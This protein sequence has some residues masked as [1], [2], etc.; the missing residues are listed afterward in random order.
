VDDLSF[1]AEFHRALDPMA[2]SAPWLAASVREGLSR[3][4]AK[5]RSARRELR[6]P[7]PAWILPA[8]AALIAIA[9]IVA[10]VVG[11]QL[12]HFNQFI[13][14]RP[15]QHGLAAPAGCPGWSANPANGMLMASD[16]VTSS[17]VAWADGALRT[18]DGGSQWTRMAPDEM[19]S[20][21]PSGTNPDVYPPA[22]VD[23]FLDSDH[24][25]LAYGYPSRTSCFDHVT[26]FS[27]SDGGRSWKRSHQINAAIQADS[28]LQLQLDFI[29]PR[30]GWLMVLAGGR[31]VPDW[32]LYSTSD[33]GMDWQL[34]STVPL[35]GSWCELKFISLSVGILGGCGN[36]SGPLPD[37]TLTPDGGQTWEVIHL[38]RPFGT[39]FSVAT[40]VFFDQRHGVVHVMVET[41]QGNTQTPSGY[42][43][44]TDD[45]GQTW[46]ALPQLAIPGNA[47]GFAFL[48]PKHFFALVVDGKTGGD[49]I[50]RTV[51]GGGTWTAVGS[52]Q[53]PNQNAPQLVFL[54]AQHGAIEEPGQQIGKGP[55]AFL[56]S[57][58][59]G[60]TW[61]DMHPR[62][63]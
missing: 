60:R 46:R 21:A 11:G 4:T 36:V 56:S 7:M 1:R 27:T 22:Y 58:D 44:V 40:P 42:L 37:L 52:V 25:W 55:N 45:G 18:T 9:I 26:V 38:P 10:V 17:S 24:A 20:D 62:V 53:L 59:G 30:H 48:D 12:L 35:M 29:D 2:P 19:L 51:D 5:A 39:M 8:V 34:V 28:S 6:R 61:K 13:P 57:G 63:S 3:R 49:S 47:A 32:F 15:P 54:D 14:V 16:R 31:I 43:A 23:Y 41:S 50:Y 33:G